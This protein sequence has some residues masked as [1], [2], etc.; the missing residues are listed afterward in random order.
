M[1][2][3]QNNPKIC[4]KICK[5]KIYKNMPITVTLFV[6]ARKFA[7]STFYSQE[8]K[9]ENRQKKKKKKKTDSP[10]KHALLC[11]EI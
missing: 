5:N 2:S 8:L 7:N 10:Y 3:I 9:R 1:L 4:N 6:V 11:V